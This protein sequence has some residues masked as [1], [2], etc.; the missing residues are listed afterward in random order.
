MLNSRNN[1]IQTV[2]IEARWP[3]FSFFFFFWS[4]F[5]FHIKRR[6]NHPKTAA[7]VV[8]ADVNPKEKKWL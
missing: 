5:A 6:G 8:I 4:P 1:P 2:N 7:A 3:L